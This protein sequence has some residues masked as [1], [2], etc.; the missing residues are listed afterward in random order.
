MI[1]APVERLQSVYERMEKAATRAGRRREAVS[2]VAVT[3]TVPLERIL[4][5]IQAG[6]TQVGENRVQEA[7]AKYSTPLPRPTF[8]L[9]GPLQSNKTKKAVDFFD[10]IQTLDRW[11][12][13]QDLNRHADALGKTQDC[14]VQVKISDEPSKSG[15]DPA[16]LP[17]F[18]D[19][20]KALPHLRIRGL[21]GIPP[22]AATG[23][24][25]RPYFQRLRRLFEDSLKS[26]SPNAF[27]PSSPNATVGDPFN[28]L[29]MG[30]S[31]DFVA[32][33]EEGSTMVRVGS[34]LF[35]PR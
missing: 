30:M 19:Q 17:E 18:L 6:V 5:F 10:L 26:S 25:A 32:A 2:L 12:L 33:I 29:S 11:E 13:A 16:A 24:S 15:L 14:L 4:P 27:K 34:A 1:D 7:L 9:I 23:D 28:I 35:G 3:K 31:S 21:M 20:L 22:L 8:H